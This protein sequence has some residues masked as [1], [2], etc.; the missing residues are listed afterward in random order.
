MS[1]L[2]GL[3]MEARATASG[4]LAALRMFTERN[5]F[6]KVLDCECARHDCK[7][8]GYFKIGVEEFNVEGDVLTSSEFHSIWLRERRRRQTA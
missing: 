1:D 5:E 4:I 2:A 6:G 3:K 7:E 8:N